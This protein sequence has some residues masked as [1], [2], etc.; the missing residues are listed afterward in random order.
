MQNAI[1]KSDLGSLVIINLGTTAITLGSLL[2]AL[3]ILILSFLAARLLVAGLGRFRERMTGS[4]TSLYI[5]EKLGGYGIVIVGV[6]FAISAHMCI[7]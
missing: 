4:A 5:L 6:F 7:R 1:A 2:V 3:A